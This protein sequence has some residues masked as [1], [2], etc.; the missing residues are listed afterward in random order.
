MSSPEFV[1]AAIED[2]HLSMSGRRQLRHYGKA[3]LFYDD[4]GE[5]VVR[6]KASHDRPDL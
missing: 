1:A 5:H 3:E 4:G 2:K 6:A